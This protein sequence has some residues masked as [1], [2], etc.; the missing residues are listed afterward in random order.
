MGQRSIGSIK[1]ID[2]QQ[3]NLP[4]RFADEL[5]QMTQHRRFTIRRPGHHQ[6]DRRVLLL[7]GSC[8]CFVAAVLLG[9][10]A[11]TVKVHGMGVHAFGSVLYF[12]YLL[13]EPRPLVGQAVPERRVAA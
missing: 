3:L 12:A 8:A 2:T 10:F 5:L 13:M 4:S 9:T 11:T 1:S 6:I 7:W